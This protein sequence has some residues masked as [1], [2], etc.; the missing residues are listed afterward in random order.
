MLAATVSQTSHLEQ[1]SCPSRLRRECQR[2][3]IGNFALGNVIDAWK[4][5]NVAQNAPVTGYLCLYLEFRTSPTHPDHVLAMY[6][7]LLVALSLVYLLDDRA[8][9]KNRTLTLLTG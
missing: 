2:R 3:P 9:T 4:R 5:A 8:G 6:V 7:G 1:A